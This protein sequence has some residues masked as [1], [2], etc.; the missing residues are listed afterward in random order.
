M[1]VD[2]STLAISTMDISTVRPPIIIRMVTYMKV[3]SSKDLEMGKE[4]VLIYQATFTLVSGKKM[5][6]MA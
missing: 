3:N 4:F 2:Q 6:R 1:Y 5:R